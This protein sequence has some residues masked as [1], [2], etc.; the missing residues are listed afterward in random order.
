MRTMRLLL[1]KM[2]INL[3]NDGVAVSLDTVNDVLRFQCFCKNKW[4]NNNEEKLTA[5]AD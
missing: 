5:M 4:I 1:Q 2:Q 3:R